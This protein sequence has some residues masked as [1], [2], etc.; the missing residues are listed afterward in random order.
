MNT[1]RRATPIWRATLSVIFAWT[2]AANMGGCPRGAGPGTGGNEN[3]NDNTEPVGDV[4]QWTSDFDAAGLG[5]MSAVW[6]SG[7]DDVFVVGGQEQAGEILHYDG[8]TWQQMNVPDL[9]RLIWVFGFGPDNVYAVG[10]GGGALHYD[11]TLWSVLET[12]TDEDLWGVWGSSP[13][14]IWI[15]GGN[16]D[17]SND[18]I[19]LNYDGCEFETIDLPAEE[20]NRNATA[21]FKVWGIGSKVFAVG[22]D[23]LIVELD[24]DTREWLQIP[25]G[26]EDDF[27]SLWGTSENNIVAVG[28]RTTGQISVYD[29]TSWTT[30][31][32]DELP[33]LLGLNAVFMVDADQALIGGLSGYA[34]TYN[35]MTGELITEFAGTNDTLHG[36]WGDG[37]GLFHVVGGLVSGSESSSGVALVRSIGD[38]GDFVNIPPQLPVTLPDPA[39]PT[40][41]LL[42]SGDETKPPAVIV[43]GSELP[44]FTAAGQGGDVVHVEPG[45]RVTG[46]PAEAADS[47]VNIAHSLCLVDDGRV[48][49]E[50]ATAFLS[51]GD[52]GC[53]AEGVFE[54][55]GR[56]FFFLS[57]VAAD[58]VNGELDLEGVA[59]ELTVTI[60]FEGVTATHTETVTLT[61]GGML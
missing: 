7:P 50:V 42:N 46:F 17:D 21:L 40:L 38:P 29:G 6:G 60:D 9:P 56:R 61:A 58:V 14:D 36:I 4:V 59:A 25:T 55:T 49:S 52:S 12:P 16:T 20:N 2:V 26:A 53:A 11:G 15:V 22:S 1:P 54:A 8:T 51:F 43:E 3:V 41:T 28:G 13:T 33:E 19:I 23:G 45:L 18:P 47:G 10:V 24:P 37:A 31:D 30:T 5:F 27:V 48:I 44:F 34:A 32:S 39:D 57:A 35:P